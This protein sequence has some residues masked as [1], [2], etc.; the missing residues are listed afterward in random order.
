M[1]ALCTLSREMAWTPTGASGV[2]GLISRKRP[3]AP[4]VSIFPA[5]KRQQHDL[6]IEPEAPVLNVVNVV[7]DS[8]RQIAFPSESI[9]LGP[10]GHA[11][12]DQMTGKVMR[13]K[14]GK[15]IDVVGP[16]GAGPDKAHFA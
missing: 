9:H 8:G 15:L 11:W 2:T 1:E 3:L 16:L 14:A 7:L 4:S 6:E 10:P 12:F 5:K 13:D